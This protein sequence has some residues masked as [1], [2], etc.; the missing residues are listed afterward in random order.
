MSAQEVIDAV[1]AA[2][3]TLRIGKD[4]RLALAG[5]KSSQDA[6]PV[7]V[8]RLLKEH[9][10]DVLRLLGLEEV[11]VYELL[12][13]DGS[14]VEHR[15][16][17]EDAPY[18]YVNWRPKGRLGWSYFPTVWSGRKLPLDSQRRK[19][20]PAEP[21]SDGPAKAREATPQALHEEP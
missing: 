6:L 12:D 7:G 4:G 20:E 19:D 11:T 15:G 14:V 10:A 16:R 9:K 8:R 1:K 17:I 21:E 2:R 18:G 13:P 3:L 5:P